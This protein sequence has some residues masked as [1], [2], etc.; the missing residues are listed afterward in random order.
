[1]PAERSRWQ[2]RR[3]LRAP[4]SCQPCFGVATEYPEKS[5]CSAIPRCRLHF[6]RARRTQFKTARKIAAD[7]HD[8][9]SIAGI[10]SRA[11]SFEMPTLIVGAAFATLLLL[12]FIYPNFW[13]D[14]VLNRSVLSGGAVEQTA[15][16]VKTVMQV[17]LVE[18]ARLD[19]HL[20]AVAKPKA[21]LASH[22]AELHASLAPGTTASAASQSD[23]PDAAGGP[24][25]ASP[26]TGI[27][28][29]TRVP[30]GP[31]QRRQITVKYGDT[32]ESIAIRYFGSKIRN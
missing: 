22:P 10:A 2:L 26:G 24:A 6:T 1:M 25:A 11:R 28:K 15:R 19:G 14:W 9:V 7:Y 20:R 30:A 27:Q 18:Q 29:Q 23:D 12:S 32:L 21:A 3:N 13:S 17:N 16:P 8:S 5:I 31:D 4:R